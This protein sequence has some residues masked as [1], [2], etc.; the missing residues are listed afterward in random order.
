M[1]QTL[2]SLVKEICDVFLQR[3]SERCFEVI[4]RR[5]GLEN[6]EAE[7]LEV[8]G[9]SYGVTRERVRQIEANVLK[10]LKPFFQ[11]GVYHKNFARHVISHHLP[12]PIFESITQFQ[13]YLHQEPFIIEPAQLNDYFSADAQKYKGELNLLM[14]CLGYRYHTSYI[15]KLIDIKVGWYANDLQ[16]LIDEAAQLSKLFKQEKELTL[17]Q[18]KATVNEDIV[19]HLRYFEPLELVTNKQG[20]EIVQMPFS[21][22]STTDR[23]YRLLKEFGK[24]TI[25]QMQ[26]IIN[27]QI[28]EKVLLESN[29]RNQLVGDKR[30]EPIGKSGVW[31]IRGSSPLKN[32]SIVKAM[33]EVLGK[34]ESPLTFDALIEAITE[35]RGDSFDH[36]SVKIYLAT[37]EQ[38]CEL[39][40]G[41]FTLAND[42]S[43]SFE[44]KEKRKQ[45]DMTHFNDELEAI[46]PIGEP[47]KLSDVVKALREKGFNP[48]TIRARL[49][50]LEQKGCIE[51]I[52][53]PAQSQRI[54]KALTYAPA[55][56]A[57]RKT[58]RQIIQ[59]IIIRLLNAHP[60][61]MMLKG[62]LYDA[63]NAEYPCVRQTFYRY[64]SEI[65]E[66][67]ITASHY[68]TK[69]YV[70][71]NG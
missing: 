65:P 23:A 18:V 2:P 60:E 70:K 47:Q 68:K 43:A 12:K 39:Q 11:D 38:F 21:T 31:R 48:Q 45:I 56:L 25:T 58:Q 62:Q 42:Q 36:K 14:E 9:A 1:L 55:K 27:E 6:Q 66:E 20:I 24:L 35:L 16:V 28:D 5:F 26:A 10:L 53:E 33:E 63:V 37:R 59:E 22:I 30:F 29:L 41:R 67:I 7:T 50:Q 19:H 69:Y 40:D 54:I 64:L 71:L 46:L 15:P 4:K 34:S 49:N 13:A 61:K 32:I 52:T 51:D 17:A 57:K 3:S 44:L 8:I